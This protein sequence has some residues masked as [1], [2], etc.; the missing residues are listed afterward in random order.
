MQEKTDATTIGKRDMIRIIARATGVRQAVAARMLDAFCHT[1]R[2]TLMLGHRVTI[3]EFGSFRVGSVPARRQYT[4]DG[5]I[6]LPAGR[7]AY[8]RPA[9]KVKQA[10]QEKET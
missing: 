4:F 3:P 2:D 6:Y 8:F 7:R 10:L 9:Q 1:V 5:V